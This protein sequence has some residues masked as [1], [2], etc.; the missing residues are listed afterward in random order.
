M[1]LRPNPSA[2]KFTGKE[3][4]GKG[5][6]LSHH[7]RTEERVLAQSEVLRKEKN[8]CA[9][10]NPQESDIGKYA[11]RMWLTGRNSLR[12]SKNTCIQTIHANKAIRTTKYG[13]KIGRRISNKL[14]VLISKYITGWAIC[15]D[16][17]VGSPLIY[18]VLTSCPAVRPVLPIS[19]QPKQNQA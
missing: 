11:R 2:T 1:R 5:G 15:S 8:P 3:E 14:I 18:D 10:A 9:S 12:K 19:H 17:W 6:F 4:T 13:A 7:S 16:S